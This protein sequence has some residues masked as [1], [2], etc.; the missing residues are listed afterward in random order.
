MLKIIQFIYLFFL[1]SCSG[2]K[3]LKSVDRNELYSAD[4]LHTVREVN[5]LLN[6]K[7]LGEVEVALKEID[8]NNLSPN[9][10]SLKRYLLGRF[11]LG[12]NDIEKAIFNFELALSGAGD[13]LILES[14]ACLGLSVGYFK[15]GIYFYFIL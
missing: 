15:I 1:I 10:V 14:Q 5:D 3:T 2:V 13:D 12:Y 9:E 6:K 11:Y 4:F 8:E 7:K